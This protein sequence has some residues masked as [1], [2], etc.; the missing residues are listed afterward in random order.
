VKLGQPGGDA[1][2]AP[3]E[4]AAFG[5]FA[6]LER[7]RTFAS[8]NDPIR[9]VLQHSKSHP[10]MLESACQAAFVVFLRA[11]PNARAPAATSRGAA[12][13]RPRRATLTSRNLHLPR[14]QRDVARVAL[15]RARGAPRQVRA[16]IAS[17]AHRQS[18]VA[19]SRGVGLSRSNLM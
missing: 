8:A 10:R 15:G 6:A 1:P 7:E 9:S 13:P 19:R 2:T 3:K 14:R 18:P 16:R 12:P 5:A 4:D 11:R 17:I